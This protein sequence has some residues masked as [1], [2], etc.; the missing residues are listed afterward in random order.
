MNKIKIALLVLISM[1]SSVALGG[2]DPVNGKEVFQN[3]CTACH[4]F[5]K[6]SK[7]DMYG[8]VLPLYG[9]VGQKAGQVKGFFYSKA[10]RK[11]GVIWDEEML[12]KYIENPMGILPGIRMQYAG[13]KDKKAREDMIAYFKD[14]MEKNQ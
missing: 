2:G 1:L 12:D 4:N 8:V 14:E 6:G 9:I 3:E 10:L 7:P 13:L 11:S 5:I